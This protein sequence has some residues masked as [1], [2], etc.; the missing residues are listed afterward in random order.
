M[1]I[2][3]AG[4]SGLIGS[5]LATRLRRDGHVI[6]RLVRRPARGPDEISWD[7]EGGSVDL[8]RLDGADAVVNLAGAD[9][10]GRRW[11][12]KYKAQI[13]DSR[14]RGTGTLAAAVARLD[15]KPEVFVVGS[16]IG[17][18][19]ATGDAPVD[20]SSPGGSGF[21]ADV[22]R[23]WEAAADPARDAGIRVVHPRT[24]LVVSP[25]GGAWGRLWPIFS[26]GLGGRLGSGEQWW[27]FVSL[28]D[29]VSALTFL[30]QPG[31]GRP[32][33][34]GPVN[35]TAPHPVRNA[36]M[37]A[38]MGRLLHRPTFFAV[39][40]MALKLV[41]GEFSTEILDSHRVLPARLQEAGFEFQ[42]PS[43]DEALA[44]AHEQR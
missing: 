2:A 35:I 33:L 5:A 44:W 23:D 30:L 15:H 19:G 21:L 18:Y 8:E 39:P 43:I 3:I 38:A 10:G 13:R 24:G 11:T 6:S 7:P 34:S 41:L 29:E 26:L 16:A 37:T 42:D 22:V 12:D 14:V 20:E 31:A 17:Y 32:E 4:A 36:E 28:R 40:G 27:S 25:H 9:V 1:R